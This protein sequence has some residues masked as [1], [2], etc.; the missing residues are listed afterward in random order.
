MLKFLLLIFVV[1]FLTYLQAWGFPVLSI[2]PNLALVSVVVISF[3]AANL[4][5]GFLL[6]LVSALILKFAPG[7]KPEML[8]FVLFGFFAVLIGKHLPWHSLLDILLLIGLGTMLSYLFFNRELLLSV[9]SLKEL[10]LNLAIGIFLFALL[11]NLWES[12]ILI[13]KL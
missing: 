7:F 1:V 2:K 9:V 11:D 13:K 3:F 10:V 12:K 6:V 8:E 4:T 5:E